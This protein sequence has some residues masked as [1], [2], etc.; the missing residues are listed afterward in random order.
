MFPATIVHFAKP[1]HMST[2]TKL[3]DIDWTSV[4]FLGRVFFGKHLASQGIS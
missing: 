1:A 2:E 3:G 4:L